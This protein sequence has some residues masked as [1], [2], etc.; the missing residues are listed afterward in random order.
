L[1]TRTESIYANS[2][3]RFT[4]DGNP[5]FEPGDTLTIR[6]QKFGAGVVTGAGTVTFT[7]VEA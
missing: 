7:L 3:R 1:N 6:M 2:A 5:L 4:L